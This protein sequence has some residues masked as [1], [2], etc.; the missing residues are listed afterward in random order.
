MKL[1]DYIPTI[2]KA[3]AAFVT[4]FAVALL[5]WLIEWTGADVP[6]DPAAIETF[7]VAAVTAFATWAIANRPPTRK[8]NP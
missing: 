8:E 1:T 7:I 2:A 3:V 6:Y 5:A 4:P